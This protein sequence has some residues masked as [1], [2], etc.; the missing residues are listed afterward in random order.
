MWVLTSITVPYYVL[1]PILYYD[2]HS[3]DGEIV[4]MEWNGLSEDVAA[5]NTKLV[6]QRV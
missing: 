6:F 2:L 4:P 3:T 5:V 1:A